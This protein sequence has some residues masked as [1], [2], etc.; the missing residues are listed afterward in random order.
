M[1]RSLLVAA[2]VLLSST[3]WA[4]EPVTL[5][6]DNVLVMNQDFNYTSVA[7]LAVRAKEL[8]AILPSNEPLYLILDSPGGSI[9]AGIEL[10][11][12]LNNLN[13]PVHTITLFAA[14][15]GFQTV[16][17]LKGK[18]LV[19]ER[20]TLMS[21]KARGSFSGEFPGQ[22][23]SRYVYY[24]SRVKGLD[25]Q[26]VSRTSGKHTEASYAA[27]I[28]NEYWCEGK[29]CMDQ[30]FADGVVA[31]KCDKSLSGTK[32]DRLTFNFM[33]MAINVDLTVSKCPTVTGI[34]SYKVSIG[35]ED[36]YDSTDRAYNSPLKKLTT[37]QIMTIDAKVKET[38]TSRT[39]RLNR[40]IGY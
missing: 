8:D 33:G 29:T 1:I 34:L 2:A 37:E 17:G 40:V 19:T 35:G 26:V 12:N 38:I 18:R 15:M 16:Q 36:F 11:E 21:H 30:G 28:E 13:R 22:L 20:G 3:S 5:T 4:G 10:I 25:K 27:L 31:P 23:D 32:E 14:S 24:L 6:E 9:D 39:G 7:A